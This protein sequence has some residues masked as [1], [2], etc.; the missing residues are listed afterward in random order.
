M[1]FIAAL[2]DRNYRF[3]WAGYVCASF[4]M[5]MDSVVLGWLVLEMT[6]SAFMVGLIGAVRFLG[7]MLGPWA[8][9]AADR[10]DRRRL[11][12][13]A[14][15]ILGLLIAWLVTLVALRRLEVW[16]LFAAT[17]TASTKCQY[18]D[19]SSARSTCSHRSAPEKAK[20]HSSDNMTSPMITWLAWRPIRA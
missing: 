8:G 7:S 20:T 9:V 18:Q 5:R 1:T 3:L 4:V 13:V 10:I 15:S 16:H 12:L 19:T 6:H 2:Y 14:S 11:I 17:H